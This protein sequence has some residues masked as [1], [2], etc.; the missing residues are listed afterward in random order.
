MTQHVSLSLD[1]VVALSDTERT[2][3]F[4]TKIEAQHFERKSSRLSPADLGDALSAFGNAEGGLIVVGIHDKKVQGL[5]ARQ[6]NDLAVA[7]MEYVEP[8]VPTRSKQLACLDAEGNTAYVMVF[9][10]GVDGKLHKN[11][12]G[13]IFLRVGDRTKRLGA[14]EAQELAHEKGTPSYDA[15]PKVDAVPDDLD[16]ELLSD[17]VK[18][19]SH[20]ATPEET[21]RARGLLKNV[22][23]RSCPTVAALL[24][25]GRTPQAH[26]A[27]ARLRVIPY[28]GTTRET[29]VG[30]NTGPER[31][32]DL[33]LPAQIREAVRHIA[34]LIPTTRRLDPALARFA[35]LPIV[36]QEAWEEAVVNAVAHRSYSLAGD[37]IRVEVFA[38][39][40]EITSPGALPG[41]VNLRNIR[42]NH[43]ARN[44]LIARVLTEMGHMRET[45]EG[46]RRMF[47]AMMRSG[48]GEPL[49]EEFGATFKVT[50]FFDSVFA[51][52]AL[53]LSPGGEPLLR[54][55]MEHGRV[56]T[57]Q[58]ESLVGRKKP[59]TRRLL[60][61]L[62]DQDLLERVELGPRDPTGYWR[63]RPPRGRARSQSAYSPRSGSRRPSSEVRRTS[64]T[65]SSW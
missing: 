64:R 24:L 62:A 22:S 17:Y 3:L 53:E 32:F 34:T 23:G 61:R 45:A 33:P 15:E 38:D 40:I 46:V 37:H 44:P 57:G 54:H 31:E 7:P 6:A 39:R 5:T 52:I 47:A 43:Y 2:A 11:R 63:V 48:F 14:L 21:L 35:D 28:R 51:T 12:A 27:Q 13:E 36:P 42:G 18:T 55:L 25:F 30:A 65:S 9:E 29:G 58:A 16:P 50:L 56:T 19:L 41:P 1:H 26:L 60:K 4:V 8:P 10:V 20:T 49:L 59:A